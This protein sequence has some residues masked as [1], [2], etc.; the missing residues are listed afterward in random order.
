MSGDALSGFST[1]PPVTE[2]DDEVPG[3]SRAYVCHLI[4]LQFLSYFKVTNR[5]KCIL[6]D[7]TH[8]HTRNWEIVVKMFLIDFRLVHGS[9]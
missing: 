7:V 8:T 3:P 1:P 2:T 9:N 5:L 6:D 4:F